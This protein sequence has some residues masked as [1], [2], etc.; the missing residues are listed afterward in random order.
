MGI[1]NATPDSFYEGSRVVAVSE[2]FKRA[3]QMLAEGADILDIGG[4]SS[5]PG[6]GH[7]SEK[8]E[9]ERVLPLVLE[10]RKHFPEAVISIDT[11][12]AKVAY[13]AI[14]AGADIINDITAGAGDSQMWNRVADVSVPYIAMHMRG[15]PQTMQ[16]LTDYRDLSAELFA[17][18]ARLKHQLFG[19]GI[20]DLIID[21]GFGF[22]K[23][24]LD[25]FHLLSELEGF[26]LLD[27]PLLVGVS[28]KSMI[29]KT[30]GISPA[31][32][33]NGT[34]AL[35]TVAWAKG[36]HIL[37]VHDVRPAVEALHLLSLLER[38]RA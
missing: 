6:A 21:P 24:R 30:L 4:Y 22:A 13:E 26:H 5:R 34:V 1:L 31:E 2:A 27:L 16:S 35:Q 12:R 23:E 29:Y 10:L 36:A 3:Q 17:Y 19:L 8:E 20:S 33:L 18:F 25:N 37:R 38:R 32:A 9:L 14:K 7:I 11:F 15:T 28:R